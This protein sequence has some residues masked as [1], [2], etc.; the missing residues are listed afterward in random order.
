MAALAKKLVME[1][2]SHKRNRLSRF[3]FTINN[4]TENDQAS[5]RV[6]NCKWIG[7]GQEVGESGTPHLQGACVLGKRLAFST[8][9]KHQAFLKA[10][11]EPMKGTPQQARD[12][13][14]K[15]GKFEEHGTLPEPGKRNDIKE[16]ASM[17][18]AG[19][20]LASIAT[21]EAGAIGLIKYSRGLQVLRSYQHKRRDPGDPPKVIWLYGPT[22]TGKTRTC[23]E[24]AERNGLTY[25][26]SSG[27]L[28]W[29]DGY[30]GQPVCILDDI[31]TSHCKFDFL[32]RLLDRYPFTVEFKG[33]CIQWSPKYI[34]ITA[35]YSSRNMWN[36]KTPEQL[37]QLT[38]RIS[39]ELASPEEISRVSELLCQQDKDVVVCGLSSPVQQDGE[40]VRSLY[41]GS[42]RETLQEAMNDEWLTSDDDLSLESFMN[43][44]KRPGYEDITDYLNIPMGHEN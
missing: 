3:V 25:W 38:R 21:T 20:S 42:P 4:W 12:Y 22:G 17:V 29:F 5:L 37:D 26:M 2:E 16:L 35:P 15:D 44:H 41:C 30:D 24:E 36:L 40:E 19:Q 6:L 11:I 9:K 28:R 43:K 27:S 34:L 23:I 8:I 13:C 10:H 32:L 18:V 33:G 31:R 7:W 39:Y 1:K 14:M